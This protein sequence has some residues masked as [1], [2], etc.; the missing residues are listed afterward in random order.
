MEHRERKTGVLLHITSLPS[1]YGVGDLGDEAYKFVDSISDKGI[2]LWQILPTGPTGFGDS[3]YAARS[4]FAGNELFISPKALYLKG[5]L[6][7]DDVLVKANENERVDYG[8]ARKLKMP[9]LFKAA[10]NFLTKGEKEDLEDFAAFRKEEGWWLEDYALFQALCAKYN[11]SRWFS[12]W[13]K[14]LRIREKKAMDKARKEQKSLVDIYCVLQYFFY[15]QWDK[16]KKYA[17]EKGVEIVGDIPI[18]VA[19]DSVDA[20]TNT[21]LLQFDE[22]CVQEASAGV[23]PDAFSATGQLWGNPLYAWDEME[24]DGY[25][26]WIKRIKANFRLADIIRID[27]F[28][29]FEAYWRVPKGE[30]TAMNGEWIKGPGQKFFDRIKEVFGSDLPIIAEDLGVITPEVE[31]LRDDNHLPGMKILQFA[32]GFDDEG[33]FDTTNEYLIH[34][35]GEV[36]V[37][38]TGTHDN[39][40][41]IGWYN[42]LDDRTKDVIR[43]YFECS[44]NEVLWK[45][46]RAL[47]MSNAMYVVFPMQDILGL[48]EEARMNVPSTCG[49]SN[50]SWKMKKEDITSP[51]LEGIKYYSKLYGRSK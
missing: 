4:A 46:I 51:S 39:N 42:S 18:F 17:N 34:N 15:T 6:D 45:M 27:H 19:S 3:P 23:P 5:W 43:R 24:K 22:N 28:R 30:D 48:G 36:S 2:S 44:D 49:T 11:D 21:K 32:F 12:V 38:Y 13:P 31:A 14:D 41:T 33:E 20:W 50:W 37:A 7:I 40:T 25:A 9:M 16:L 35:I 29:G 1:Q 26:W 8:E 10:A 47:L